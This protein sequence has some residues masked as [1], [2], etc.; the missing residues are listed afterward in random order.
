MFFCSEC[1]RAGP[2][3]VLGSSS[4]H[5]AL[6]ISPK[7]GTGM[8]IMWDIT[9][10]FGVCFHIRAKM[11]ASIH[12][13]LTQRLYSAI[14][15]HHFFLTV[16]WKIPFV[17][18]SLSKQLENSECSFPYY[19]LLQDIHASKCHM[20]VSYHLFPVC[21]LLLHSIKFCAE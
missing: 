3:S 15:K 2:Y 4:N 13:C 9:R 5:A 20:H 17:L 8:G 11:F 7:G 14:N 21:T 16:F 1:I 6:T 10:C 12:H 18:H 19:I